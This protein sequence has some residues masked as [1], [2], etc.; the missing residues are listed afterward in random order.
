EAPTAGAAESALVQL[1]R[2]RPDLIMMDVRLPGR[3]GLEFAR[4]IRADQMY[5]NVRIVALTAYAMKSDEE[6]ARA[7]GCDGY[8]S[9]PIDTRSLPGIVARYLSGARPTSP[10]DLRSR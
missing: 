6:K 8:L 4:R 1:P 5:K 10:N 9:K 7:A 2:V 3:D